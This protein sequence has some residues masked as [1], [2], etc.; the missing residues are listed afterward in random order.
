MEEQTVIQYHVF[1]H[2]GSKIRVAD[3]GQKSWQ[4][5]W[6]NLRLATHAAPSADR[7]APQP[8]IIK[9]NSRGIKASIEDS[10]SFMWEKYGAKPYGRSSVLAAE[11]I[12]TVGS[13]YFGGSGYSR[14]DHRKVRR[15]KKAVLS[16]LEKVFGDRIVA[17]IYHQDETAPHLHV[18]VMPLVVHKSRKC[19]DPNGRKARY[20]DGQYKLSSR[21]FFTRKKMVGWQD[22][23]GWAVEHL[24]LLRGRRGSKATHREMRDAQRDLEKGLAEVI[25]HKIQLEK[26][27]ETANTVVHEYED[28]RDEV[29]LLKKS[30]EERERIN[31]E[32]KENLRRMQADLAAQASRIDSEH[33]DLR[34][35]SH[36]HAELQ[37][38]L[39]AL[40]G[41]LA[42]REKKVLEDE[43]GQ[44]LKQAEIAEQASRVE[45]D[46]EKIRAV[47][48]RFR[49]IP[50]EQVIEKLG[51]KTDEAGDL[52]THYTD[53]T[54]TEFKYRILKEAEAF[55]IES[56][57]HQ[58]G[59]NFVWQ[60]V[61]G[62]KGAIDLML[63][64]TRF[65][66][67]SEA[68]E[69]L[70]EIFPEF[71]DGIVLELLESSNPILWKK[72]AVRQLS[73]TTKLLDNPSLP[74]LSARE[75]SQKGERHV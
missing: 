33:R 44:K 28:L 61:G 29:K 58:G 66:T 22:E 46:R 31:Q 72:L 49:T 65:G 47:A 54:K 69:R 18:Y 30:L 14:W 57:R 16:M 24:G 59:G 40:Q 56:Y 38:R 63:P 27:S 51:F 13:G 62:G 70:A 67:V 11:L 75:D 36:Q 6:H 74:P 5:D 20:G 73:T 7:A 2:V 71:S 12:F 55:R 21:A 1:L 34:E 35:R 64:F 45:R 3:L 52:A 53:H 19:W 32:E 41:S 25:E 8:Q 17:I 43:E 60:K 4:H 48:A 23:Y 37:A 26:I 50:V 42:E 68:C 10:L 9:G 39:N 15:W